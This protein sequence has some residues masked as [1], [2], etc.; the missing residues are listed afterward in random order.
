M[1]R[2]FCRLTLICDVN[3]LFFKFQIQ[4]NLWHFTP[5]R[6]VKLICIYFLF[7][8]SNI[9]AGS[10]NERLR[11][12]CKTRGIDCFRHDIDSA[13]GRFMPESTYV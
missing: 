10:A 6:C 13:D 3:F 2:S 5:G 7:A 11:K 1:Y 12:L 4:Q 9:V 8:G